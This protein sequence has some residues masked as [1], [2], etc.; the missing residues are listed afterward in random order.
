MDLSEVADHF[1]AFMQAFWLSVLIIGAG[2]SIRERFW[3]LDATDRHSAT[4][5]HG[6]D[7]I[8]DLKGPGLS[9]GA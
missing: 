8:D 6:P 4:V 2:I 9:P 5:D 1:V 7:S 3:E